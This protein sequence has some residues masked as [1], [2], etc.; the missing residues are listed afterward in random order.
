MTEQWA[1]LGK[2]KAYSVFY[3]KTTMYSPK[4]EMRVKI[5]VYKMWDVC[6]LC[7]ISDVD[8]LACAHISAIPVSV[9]SP[10]FTS[11]RRV[12]HYCLSQPPFIHTL[13]LSQVQ[14]KKT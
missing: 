12:T 1:C 2:S 5:C 9:A 3:L 10:L 7:M 11:E 14:V 8:S 13:I 6:A 4:Y